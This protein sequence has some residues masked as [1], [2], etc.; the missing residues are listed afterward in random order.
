MNGYLPA[1]ILQAVGLV[2]LIAAAVFWG[3]TGRESA[4]LVSAA[5]SLILLG[6]YRGAIDALKRKDTPPTPPPPKEDEQ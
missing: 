4:L 5:M 6:A 2:L 3:F 1:R